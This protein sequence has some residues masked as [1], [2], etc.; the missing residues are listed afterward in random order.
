MIG[1]I[2]VLTLKDPQALNYHGQLINTKYDLPIISECIS[3]QENGIHDAS[4]EEKAIPKIITLGRRLADSG[5][6]ILIVS[7]AADPAVLQ[8]RAL[9][10]LPVIGAGS[11]ASLL[12]LAS[13]KNTGVIGITEEVPAVVKNTLGA[14]LAVI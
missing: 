10:G 11:A 4:T 5:C 7:C 8:L 12:A 13:G 9:T 3:D 14:F 2:R 6:R 1:L